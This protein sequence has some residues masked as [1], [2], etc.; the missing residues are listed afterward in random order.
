MGGWT[1]ICAVPIV[2]NCLVNEEY[3]T[4]LEASD[5]GIGM[6]VKSYS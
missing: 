3:E 2:A 6:G 1:K 4:D 5:Q